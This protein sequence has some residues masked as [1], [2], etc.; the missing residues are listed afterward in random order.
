MRVGRGDC[1]KRRE[2]TPHGAL[3]IGEASAPMGADRVFKQRIDIGRKSE[4]VRALDIGA[5]GTR[6]AP[7]LRRFR[8][9]AGE[10]AEVL[11]GLELSHQRAKEF[12]ADQQNQI[13]TAFG[14]FLGRPIDQRLGRVAAHM[15]ID[16]AAWRGAKIV[17]ER[18]GRIGDARNRQV[19]NIAVRI[20]REPD[21]AEQV[22]AVRG[23]DVE[24]SVGERQLAC[25]AQHRQRTRRLTFPPRL[26][27]RADQDGRS[28]VTHTPCSRPKRPSTA[29]RGGKARRASAVSIGAGASEMGACYVRLAHQ[30][31]SA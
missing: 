31:Q 8:L 12:R 2:Q 16:C 10:C 30:F 4:A 15:R 20:D 1:A 6:I 24:P 26:L 28:G 9:R 22:H 7:A 5:A 27:A 25:P 19:P 29:S 13:M 11:A 23:R 21:D 14:D 17:T 3:M 18:A